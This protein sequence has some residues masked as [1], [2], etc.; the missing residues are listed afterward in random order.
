MCEYAAPFI[1]YM[2]GKRRL[3]AKIL[4]HFPTQPLLGYV[5]PFLG[6]GAVFWH[7]VARRR[8]HPRTL[9]YLRLSDA[10]QDLMRLWHDI[11]RRGVTLHAEVTALEPAYLKEKAVTYYEHRYAWN[12][13][14]ERRTSATQLFLR[15]TGYNGQWRENAHGEFNIPHGKYDRLNIAPV[16][17]FHACSYILQTLSTNVASWN[18]LHH[19]DWLRAVTMQRTNTVNWNED[20][21][22]R[23]VFYFDPPYVGTEDKYTASGFK[24]KEHELL[25]QQCAKLDREG[26]HVILSNSNCEETREMKKAHWPAGLVREF[27]GPRSNSCK[28][29]RPAP[30][31]LITSAR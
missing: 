1:K 22:R 18:L 12:N 23:V 20:D 25:F 6:G 11:A 2:G 28:E 8:I 19:E 31:F 3:C 26:Y 13:D 10:N 5:E 21:R 14:P 27:L 30:E 7:A 29:R 16:E 17:R 9:Q 4:A 15:A 24:T